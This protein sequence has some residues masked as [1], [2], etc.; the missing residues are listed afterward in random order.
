MASSVF[1]HTIG[2]HLKGN[3]RRLEGNRRRLEGE[4]RRWSRVVCRRPGP[5]RRAS[6]IP[7]LSKRRA[8]THWS[9][10]GPPHFPPTPNSLLSHPP[11]HPPVHQEAFLQTRGTSRLMSSPGTGR[12]ASVPEMTAHI[13]AP[14]STSKHAEATSKHLEAVR[15]ASRYSEV[16]LEVDQNQRGWLLSVLSE[17]QHHSTGHAPACTPP[18]HCSVGLHPFASTGIGRDSG[19]ETQALPPTAHPMQWLVGAP[20]KLWPPK[21][22]T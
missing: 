12:K 10:D 7:R 9:A 1:E 17:G 18:R 5:R 6:E 20:P 4:R 15:G 16:D 14:R 13:F 3:R 2:R 22:G 8:R 19:A 21:V 11:P